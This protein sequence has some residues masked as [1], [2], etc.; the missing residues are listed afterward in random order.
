MAPLVY[1]DTDCFHHLAT[2]FENRVL[3]ADLRDNILFSPM[4]L[5]EVFSHLAVEWGPLVHRQIQRLPRWLDKRVGLLPSMTDAL[6]RIAFDVAIP[7]DGFTQSM[8]ETLN[9]LMNY[10]LADVFEAAKAGRDQL[11]NTKTRDARPGHVGWPPPC[12]QIT[13]G[14]SNAL[15]SALSCI[16]TWRNVFLRSIDIRISFCLFTTAKI[17]ATRRFASPWKSVRY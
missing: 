10:Q 5:T 14:V 6:A 16:P 4:T 8:Q 9:E 2:T 11:A 3:P 13:G 15:R 1:F 7:D 17:V 12:S